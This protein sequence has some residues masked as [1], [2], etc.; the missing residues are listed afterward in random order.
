M[1]SSRVLA[2][3]LILSWASVH[4]QRLSPGYV[5]PQP[6]LD[7]A[8]KAIG[9]DELS[10]SRFP[11][12]ATRALSASSGSSDKNVDWPRGEPLANYTRTMNWD[13]RT[14][15][16]EFDRKP[17]LNPASWKYGD[18]LDGRHA[19]PAAIAPDLHRQRPV[20]LAHRRPGRRAG[21]G[22][23][24]RCRAVA[25]R[26]VAQ[27]ATDSSRRRDCPAPTRWRSG[28][29]SSA[30]WGATARRRCPRRSRSSRSACS[31][32][33]R[34][35]ATINK[36]HMLQRIHTWV[37]HPVLG[38]MNYEHEFTN[39]SYVD[40]RQRHTVPDRLASPRRLGRQLQHADD[41]RRPQRVRRHVQGRQGE[42]VRRSRSPSPRPCGRR[43]SRFEWRRSRWPRA[44]TCSA[45]RR[46][47][48]SPSS[49]RTSSP[50]SRRRS[51]RT[52]S[53][54]VI[55]EVARLDAEQADPVP[56]QH[57]P[58]LRSHRRPPHLPAH[59][60]DHRHA[61]EEL[62]LL[63]PRR[64]ELR[65]PDAAAGHGVA[66]AADR[67]DRGLQRRDREGELRDHRRHRES[68]TCI[69][70]T[71]W[72]ARRGHADGLPPAREAA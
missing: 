72:P 3:L 38:D 24:G 27:P 33:Y 50:S 8:A 41:H 71:R 16:E 32:K 57:A 36:E 12:P 55:E 26:D 60:R 49:S 48:A 63:Q 2:L 5:D 28:A 53:L 11:A 15:K 58:A 70:S 62:R 65:A 9:V 19:A 56:G 44:C 68:C 61:L 69:T 34:V 45:A 6:V 43:P 1:A 14:M 37:P 4:A 40:A 31:G 25:A 51:T 10:A 29:G 47:T 23:P 21:G 13:A 17:G 42:R 54:A 35:D 46:T 30:R 59:R 67:V 18:R 52:R 66:L 39:E 7:A 20:R 64:L 22:A